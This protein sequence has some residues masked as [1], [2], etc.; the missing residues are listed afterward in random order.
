MSAR[1]A[2]DERRRF[3]ADLLAYM[4]LEEKLGQLD[5]LHSPRDPALETAIA[6]GR[7]GGIAAADPSG[8]W[9]RIAADQSRLGIPLLLAAEL[10]RQPLSGWALAASWDGDLAAALGAAAAGE[11]FHAGANCI[12]DVSVAIGDAA[13]R[14]N[15]AAIAA[16]QAQLGAALAASFA[17]GGDRARPGAS[18]GMPSILRI[19]G[20]SAPSAA[21]AVALA[22]HSA[23]HA[24]DC[25]ELGRDA[26][27]KVGFSGLLLAEC[28]R[29]AAVVAEHF[30]TT[31]AKSHV[32]AAERAI[33]EGIIGEHEIDGAVRGVLAVKHAFGLFR[34]DDRPGAGTAANDTMLDAAELVRK[35]AVLLRNEAGLLPLSPV[36]DRVLVVGPGDGIGAACASALSRAGIGQSL[37]PGLAMRRDGE[38]WSDPVAGD[39]F[40]LSLTRDAAQRADF[41]LVA[42]DDRHFVAR[43]QGP[44]RQ[45]GPATLAMLRAVAT[46]GSRMFAVVS[47]DEPVDLAEAD[48][49]FAAVLHCWGMSAGFEE[50]LADLLSGRHGPQGRMPVAAG[51]FEFGHGLS[52][53]ESV[54]SGFTVTAG[55]DHLVAALRIRNAG[56]FAARETAQAYVMDHAGRPRLVAFQHVTLAPGEDVP[57]RFELGLSELGVIGESGRLELPT[58]AVEILVGKSGVRLLRAEFTITPALARAIRRQQPTEMWLAAG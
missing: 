48:Q 34:R 23:V 7:V 49:H 35:S 40:A 50:A 21:C 45:P 53:A 47:T 37:A 8:R 44:W 41:V 16:E 31:R 19:V 10:S 29:L 2:S 24:L 14:P 27:L 33:A 12:A 4:T 55:A 52:Y 18:P 58:G 26:A 36:S 38:P 51:R 11:L 9:Q 15:G 3:V 32:E 46:A 28:Q 20:P 5:L 42:L 43:G 54:F 57:V 56:S 6:A 13:L 25:A 30:A 39:H 17:S 22:Q 1:A